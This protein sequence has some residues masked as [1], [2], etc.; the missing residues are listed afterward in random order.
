MKETYIPEV[1][2]DGVIIPSSLPTTLYNKLFN[3]EYEDQEYSMNDLI[4]DLDNKTFDKPDT[5][6]ISNARY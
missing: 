4:N 5:P 3:P 6:D 2:S 1:D